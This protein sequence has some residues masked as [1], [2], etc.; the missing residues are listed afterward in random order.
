MPMLDDEARA[1]YMYITDGTNTM[2]TMDVNTRAGFF[3][4]TDGTTDLAI[5]V[6]SS[7]LPAN[8][9]GLLVQG[10]DGTNA[11]YLRTDTAGQLQVVVVSGAGGVE[12]VS[13]GSATIAKGTP[14]VA[15]SYSPAS[16]TEYIS[17]ITISSAARMKHEIQWGT[18]SS[19][20]TTMVVFTNNANLTQD[21]VLSEVHDLASTE[22]IQVYSTN[23]E[24]RP[25]PASDS[26]VYVTFIG[27]Q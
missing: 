3:E 16:G 12:V 14:A 18:T 13:Y 5:G 4:L 23:L 24:P 8:D 9:S 6:D 21:I 7:A 26:D 11:R 10:S 2:P 15:H 25:S 1:G 27:H 22:T 20:A 17:Q 19:E